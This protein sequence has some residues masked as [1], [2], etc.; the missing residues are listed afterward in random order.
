LSTF[1]SEFGKLDLAVL[2]IDF[3]AIWP[4]SPRI[5][6]APVRPNKTAPPSLPAA[7]YLTEI[8]ATTSMDRCWHRRNC[9]STQAVGD[10]S[11]QDGGA[12]RGKKDAV[13]DLLPGLLSIRTRALALGTV[14]LLS[15]QAPQ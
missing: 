7:H 4:D 10:A 15:E 6:L 12:L 1:R 3:A 14:F 11:D 13:A 8:R 9:R 5:A 2:G